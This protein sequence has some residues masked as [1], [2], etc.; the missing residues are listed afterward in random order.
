MSKA[1]TKYKVRGSN[2]YTYYLTLESELWHIS[3]AYDGQRA[4]PAEDGHPSKAG[5]F[6]TADEAE[7]AL[8]AYITGLER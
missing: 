2:G 6:E 5:G 4:I 7:E 8:E 1:P 3:Q